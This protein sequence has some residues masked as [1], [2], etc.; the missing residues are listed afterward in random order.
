MKFRTTLDTQ[1]CSCPSAQWGLIRVLQYSTVYALVVPELVTSCLIPLIETR[2][3]SLLAPNG[4]VIR[5]IL[6]KGRDQFSAD[7]CPHVFWQLWHTRGCYHRSSL[8]YC[9]G[10]GVVTSAGV[11]C[12]TCRSR[13]AVLGVP[14]H[15]SPRRREKE[16]WE[17]FV[18]FLIS[19]GEVSCLNTEGH[20]IVPPWGISCPLLCAFLMKEAQVWP[21][22]MCSNIFPW[23]FRL[24]VTLWQK[25]STKPN[26]RLKYTDN[27]QAVAHS[28]I[29]RS[30][31]SV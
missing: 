11:N 9:W 4:K 15:A 23:R 2:A 31:S 27:R 30:N 16:W 6:T 19:Q 24:D 29:N 28:S 18:W 10:W 21:G 14:Y 26:Q 25:M 13:M 17:L 5:V 8:T 3:V 20:L 1:E 7:L 22:A 12:C